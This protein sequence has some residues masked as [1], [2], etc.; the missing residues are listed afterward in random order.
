MKKQGY[1]TVLLALFLL[2]GCVDSSLSSESSSSSV[3]PISGF[4]DFENIDR[5]SLKR[6]FVD[7]ILAN[8]NL[9][10]T[11]DI[12][13][14]Y[15]DDQELVFMNSVGAY[16]RYKAGN[17]EQFD[18]FNILEDEQMYSP[19]ILGYD[20]N[21]SIIYAIQSKAHIQ[22]ESVI[23]NIVAFNLNTQELT[24]LSVNLG[25][26]AK[27]VHAG[28][29]GYVIES[30]SFIS[31]FDGNFKLVKQYSDAVFLGSSKYQSNKNDVVMLIGE[32]A[33]AQCKVTAYRGSSSTTV[34]LND[35]CSDV[36]RLKIPSPLVYFVINER[37]Y[38][39]NAPNNEFTRVPLTSEGEKVEYLVS[40]QYYTTNQIYGLKL[41]ENPVTVFNS[42]MNI[43]QST[44]AM[45][46]VQVGET[47]YVAKEPN[48]D[49]YVVFDFDHNELLDIDDV[50]TYTRVDHNFLIVN[51]S[52]CSIMTCQDIYKNGTEQV[53]DDIMRFDAV[54]RNHAVYITNMTESSY[55][56]M[57]VN[58]DTNSTKK[59]MSLNYNYDT[60]TNLA[61]VLTLSNGLITIINQEG[62]DYH[63]FKS[64]GSLIETM[65]YVAY[66]KNSS[67][68][69][70]VL[71][72]RDN[73]DVL[74]ID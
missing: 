54:D 61:S 72:L 3:S 42:T 53:L 29:D 55:D 5:A 62:R 18:I 33:T 65:K 14:I 49:N 47:F 27:F 15:H 24:P 9:K 43:A 59:L 4:T 35:S 48:S 44:N 37:L 39:F 50:F 19:G 34:M 56:I 63:I 23:N 12:T 21:Q 36:D 66:H 22:Q 28:R 13:V 71:L 52:N 60:Y 46:V 20:K 64:D 11:N 30:S 38:Q 73:G 17:L 26:N 51:N 68:S 2:T 16:Y 45:D 32:N 6:E 70:Q 1:V 31:V 41:S 10:G 7:I 57:H 74:S 67:G 58:F 69:S 25:T 8:T 40:N